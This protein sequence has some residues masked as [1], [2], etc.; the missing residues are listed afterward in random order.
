[1]GKGSLVSRFS[2]EMDARI[3]SL[4]RTSSLEFAEDSAKNEAGKQQ[5]LSQP[6]VAGRGKRHTKA[7]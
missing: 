7:N 3:L 2:K 5:S 6:T 4:S 1:M